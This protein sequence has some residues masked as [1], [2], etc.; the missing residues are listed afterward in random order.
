MYETFM[1]S[2]P[3]AVFATVLTKVMNNIVISFKCE[4]TVTARL[5]QSTNVH[6]FCSEGYIK[7]EHARVVEQCPTVESAKAGSIFSITCSLQNS[8]LHCERC[9]KK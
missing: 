6:T 9:E 5:L 3:D 8:S 7:F 4:E 1:Y 2:N